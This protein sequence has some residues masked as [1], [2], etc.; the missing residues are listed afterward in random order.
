MVWCEC[1]LCYS[2]FRLYYGSLG[3]FCLV[4]VVVSC[5]LVVLILMFWCVYYDGL[6]QFCV[7]CLLLLYRMF[8]MLFWCFVLCI[9]CVVCSMLMKLVLVELLMWWLSWWLIWCI[10]VRFSVLGIFIIVLILVGMKFVFIRGWLMFFMC[11]LLM[12]VRLCQFCL[13][14]MVVLQLL[15]NIDIFGFVYRMWV[16]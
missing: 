5:V 16:L 8:M 3:N 9:Y 7:Q 1:C 11:E 14:V 4:I 6:Q 2:V 12:Q 10:V 13:L 15:K